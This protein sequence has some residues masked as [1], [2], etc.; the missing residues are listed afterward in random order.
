[1]VPRPTLQTNP[2]PP[3]PALLSTCLQITGCQQ[4]ALPPR[5]IVRARPAT[6]IASK[7]GV[8]QRVSGLTATRPSNIIVGVAAATAA[9][10]A[11]S[12]TCLLAWP[13]GRRPLTGLACPWHAGCGLP[14]RRQ[15]ELQHRR[16]QDARSG[17]QPPDPR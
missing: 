6:V 15:A 14:P 10:A 17:G 5:V 13:A 12:C 4:T 1:L 2:P 8:A 9:A 7:W 11:V 3:P 16:H